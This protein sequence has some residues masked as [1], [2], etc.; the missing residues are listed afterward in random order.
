MTTPGTQHDGRLADF[1]LCADSLPPRVFDL[2]AAAARLPEPDALGMIALTGPGTRVLLTAFGLTRSAAPG[3]TPGA[4]DL[5]GEGWGFLAAVTA[6]RITRARS[7]PRGRPSG[8][9]AVRRVLPASGAIPEEQK[10]SPTTGYY[11]LF[12]T[13]TPQDA[14]AAAVVKVVRHGDRIHVWKLGGRGRVCVRSTG[15]ELS[16]TSAVAL[17][18]RRLVPPAALR[19]LLLVNAE[20]QR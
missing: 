15:T 1:Q 11:D 18:L 14:P 4:V 7:R 13:G 2:F 20:Q 12:A 5:T 19:D 8:W 10:L 3:T 9:V 16:T 6:G 17:D